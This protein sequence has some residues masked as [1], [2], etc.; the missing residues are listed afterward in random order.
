MTLLLKK[1]K[2]FPAGLLNVLGSIVIG[3]TLGTHEGIEEAFDYRRQLQYRELTEKN[4]ISR[5]RKSLGTKFSIT[6]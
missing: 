1:K 2:K 6:H 5:Y 4:T 3:V